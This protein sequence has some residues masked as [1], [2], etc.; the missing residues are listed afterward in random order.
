MSHTR[1]YFHYG[2]MGA[3]KEAVDFLVEMARNNRLQ[4]APILVTETN[5][6]S[7]NVV[8]APSGD[9]VNGQMIARGTI[10]AK[11]EFGVS[12]VLTETCKGLDRQ[13]LQYSLQQRVN[14]IVTD[15]DPGPESLYSCLCPE[16]FLMS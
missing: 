5:T 2:V 16:L 3:M 4:S 9:T 11:T 6:R 15:Q 7:F 1:A 14:S 13:T 12:I 8:I 10:S